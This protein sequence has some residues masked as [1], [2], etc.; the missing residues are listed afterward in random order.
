MVFAAH[1]LHK[2]DLHDKG[3]VTAEHGPHGHGHEGKPQNLLNHGHESWNQWEVEHH[4]RSWVEID[5]H[6]K[7]DFHGIGFKS[8]A[9][10]PRKAPTEVKILEHRVVH[11]PWHEIAHKHL[12][13][14]LKNH[15]EVFF[16]DV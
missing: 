5:F 15:E 8:A 10:H 11:G 9:D 4:N 3:T 13:F 16:P 7:L 2:Y 12:E 14:H 6:D 1:G